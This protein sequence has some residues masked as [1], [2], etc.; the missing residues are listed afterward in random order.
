MHR[1]DVHNNIFSDNKL[2]YQI[3]LIIILYLT[4]Y[5]VTFLLDLLRYPLVV[6]TTLHTT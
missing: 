3:I 5:Y 1:Q 6:R 2:K 4:S